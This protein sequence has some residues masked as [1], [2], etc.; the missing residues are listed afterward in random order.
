MMYEELDYLITWLDRL[1]Y[2]VLA[3]MA[4]TVCG[5]AVIGV[6]LWKGWWK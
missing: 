1:G 5:I 4:V 2:I 3:G 6:G